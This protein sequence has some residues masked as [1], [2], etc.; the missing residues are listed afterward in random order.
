MTTDGVSTCGGALHAVCKVLSEDL[1]NGAVPSAACV[2]KYPQ[3]VNWK[4]AIRTIPIDMNTVGVYTRATTQVLTGTGTSAPPIRIRR[5]EIG[6]PR[7]SIGPQNLRNAHTL[8]TSINPFSLKYGHPTPIFSK[9]ISHKTVTDESADIYPCKRMDFG[10]N[11]VLYEGPNF[12][13]FGLSPAN[14]PDKLK[15]IIFLTTRVGR[16]NNGSYWIQSSHYLE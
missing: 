13:D 7:G 9:V 5:Q 16:L 6:S 8:K 14:T 11:S 15:S 3:L 12:M 10:S 2:F 1:V 4:V